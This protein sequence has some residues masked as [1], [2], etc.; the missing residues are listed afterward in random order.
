MVDILNGI[1]RALSPQNR[2]VPGITSGPIPSTLYVWE[3]SEELK[4]VDEYLQKLN[5]Q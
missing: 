1:Q 2:G 4:K 5:P 3:A